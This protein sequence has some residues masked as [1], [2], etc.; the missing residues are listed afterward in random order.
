MIKTYTCFNND[1]NT[2][3]RVKC[4]AIQWTGDNIDE[5]RD[6]TKSLC[7]YSCRS[8]TLKIDVVYG[9]SV[10]SKYAKLEDYIVKFN[11]EEPIVYTYDKDL[12]EGAFDEYIG[13]IKIDIPSVES[14]IDKTINILGTE[15]TIIRRR[16]SEDPVLA[17]LAGYCDWTTKQIVVECNATSDGSLGNMDCYYR[18]VIRHEIVH[19]FLFESGLYENSCEAS[20]WARNEEMVEWIA[21]QGQKIYAAWKDA[22]VLD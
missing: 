4:Q 22:R 17:R 6:F 2:D 5:V 10:S 21:R 19:A 1:N 11:D 9:E 13:D 12:F 3:S 7:E 15:W 14:N 16:E 20:E 8:R 18:K